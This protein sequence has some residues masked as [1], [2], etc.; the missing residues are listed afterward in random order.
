MHLHLLIAH[1][2]VA[3]ILTGAAADLAGALAR[4]DA[5][6]RWAG[7]LLVIG[8]ATALLALFTGGDALA[9]AAARFPAGDP[10][11]EAHPQWGAVGSWLLLGGALLRA[12]WRRSL[13]GPRGWILL[14]V[15]ILSAAVVLGIAL[16]GHAI[17]HG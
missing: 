12:A 1:F 4:R 6:R 2:P 17:A 3:L 10:R 5:L 15:A 14:G 16:T 11:L 13:A 8:G 9:R 7:A